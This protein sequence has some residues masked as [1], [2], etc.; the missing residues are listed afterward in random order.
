MRLFQIILFILTIL[1]LFFFFFR[2]FRM[3][4]RKKRIETFS[5]LKEEVVFFSFYDLIAKLSSFLGKL[6]FLDS[7][8]IYYDRFIYEEGYLKKGMDYISVK[9]LGGTFLSFLYLFCGAFL[10]RSLSL[11]IFFFVFLLGMLFVHLVALLSFKR[12]SA[13]LFSALVDALFVFTNELKSGKSVEWALKNTIKRREGIVKK[14]FQKVYRE[15]EIGLSLGDAFYLFYERTNISFLKEV[16]IL[17]QLLKREDVATRD[18]LDAVLE[19]TMAENKRR[20]HYKRMRNQNYIVALL[21]SLLLLVSF[22][23]FLFNHPS[24]FSLLLS[25]YR[26]LFIGLEG[27]FYLFYIL[28][29]KHLVRRRYL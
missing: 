7:L 22:F 16:S 28:L 10:F 29:M 14:E 26:L 27:V 17:F 2:Y 23:L 1:V 11:E 5:S 21:F 12:T 18:V 25:K 19:M 4:K 24:F 15:V 6:V 8:A 13:L 20:V 9:L 3:L